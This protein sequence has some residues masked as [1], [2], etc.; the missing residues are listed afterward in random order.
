MP[1]A[2]QLKR[3]F[4]RDKFA[5][6]APE[7]VSASMHRQTPNPNSLSAAC[8]GESDMAKAM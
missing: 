3:R 6:E 5:G 2:T 7:V 4:L 1:H 8:G